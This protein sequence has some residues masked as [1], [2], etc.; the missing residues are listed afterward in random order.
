MKHG[1]LYLES[2]IAIVIIGSL[3]L[4]FFADGTI[5]GY[6]C[7]GGGISGSGSVCPVDHEI[8]V[9]SS[10][11]H[12][13][14]GKT[15]TDANGHYSIQLPAGNYVMYPKEGSISQ[16]ISVNGFQNPKIDIELYAGVQ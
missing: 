5:S 8:D 9:Y 10:D 16:S 15:S 13:I 4:F 7:Y 14:I 6:A 12:T 3:L 2:G 11:G 1:Y